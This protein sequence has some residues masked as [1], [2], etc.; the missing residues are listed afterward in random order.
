MSA[1]TIYDSYEEIR[2]RQKSIPLDL[3]FSAHSFIETGS[4]IPLEEGYRQDQQIPEVAPL[5]A[6]HA[7]EKLFLAS[8]PI[9][10]RVFRDGDLFFAEN[11]T[12]LVCGTGESAWD[13]IEELES[14]IIHFYKYYKDLPSDG[15][16]GDAKRL[17]DLYE[18]LL[19]EEQ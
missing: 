6:V 2:T 19:I 13:A 12:L 9:R 15:V 5:W 4:E 14:H 8:R 11:E 17:K 18:D 7:G 1:S 16:I 3:G 10:V